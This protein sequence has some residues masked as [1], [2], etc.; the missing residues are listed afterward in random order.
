MITNMYTYVINI[1]QYNILSGIDFHAESLIKADH[2]ALRPQENRINKISC[3]SSILP[4]I[5]MPMFIHLLSFQIC[6]CLAVKDLS[7]GPLILLT[8][9][10][11]G[12]LNHSLGS[13]IHEIGHNLAYGHRRPLWNRALGMICN[14]PMGVPLSVTYKKYHSDHH[15]YLGNKDLDADVPTKIECYLFRRPITRVVW[16]ILHPVIHGIRPFIK[17]PDPLTKLEFINLICQ[18]GFDA[19]IYN[20]LGYKALFYCVFGTL[21]GLGLHPLAGHFISEH[22]MFTKG[23]ATQS[24]YG[25][26][27]PILFNVGYHVEH[28]DFP[29]ISWRKLPEV[30]RMAPEYYDN[31]AHHTSWLKVIWDFIFDTDMGPQGHGAAYMVSDLRPQARRDIVKGGPEAEVNSGTHVLKNQSG[32]TRLAKRNT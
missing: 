10:V 29:Y 22:Y 18:L 27:N 30:K 1:R 26:L 4:I 19:A 8:Y 9:V 17:K 16:L 2:L 7:W 25:S 14:L 5:C 3:R 20:I 31:L 21:F 15:R 28:H 24:Y 23:Q 12:T 11:S 13:A 32:Q 6:M